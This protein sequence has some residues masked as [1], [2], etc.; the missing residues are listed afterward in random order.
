V[1]N[2]S[3]RRVNPS[4]PDSV[5]LIAKKFKKYFKTSNVESS[6]STGKP[7]RRRTLKKL[8]EKG[9]RDSRKEFERK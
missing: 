8:S 7:R 3:R 5:A 2:L 4:K 1:L 6:R 9:G